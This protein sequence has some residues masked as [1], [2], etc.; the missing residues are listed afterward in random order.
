[1]AAEYEPGLRPFAVGNAGLV[2]ICENILDRVI[3]S[4]DNPGVWCPRVRG[5]RSAAEGS[6][7]R[8]RNVP[9]GG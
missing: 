2:G 4:A 8:L 3:A 6:N 9:L 5:V 1:M 7:R